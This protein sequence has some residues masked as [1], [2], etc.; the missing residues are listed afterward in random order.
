MDEDAFVVPAPRYDN[1]P[2]EVGLY[3]GVRGDLNPRLLGRTGFRCIVVGG[4]VSQSARSKA[5][6]EAVEACGPE[7]CGYRRISRQRK[8]ALVAK[9]RDGIDVCRTV[10]RERYSHQRH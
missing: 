10:G 2:G 3:Y 8:S 6:P 1:R 7:E 4:W 5:N 9:R